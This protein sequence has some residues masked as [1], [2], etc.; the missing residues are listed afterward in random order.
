MELWEARQRAS[1]LIQKTN[2]D[3]D[4]V[5]AEMDAEQQV[6]AEILS[7]FTADRDKTLARVNAA[8]FISNGVLWAVAEA[9]DIPTYRAP[10]LAIPSGTVGIIAGVVPSIASMYTLKAINGKKKDSEAEPNM[11]AK[12]F[13]YP[14][15]A[16]I[17]Y[18]SSVWNYLHESPASEPGAKKRVDQ[19]IDRWIGDANIP[20]FNDR[21]S[22]KQLDVI[23]ASISQKKRPEYRHAH[24][25]HRDAATA[26]L[27]SLQ[28]EAA[29]ARTRHG[30]AWREA[31]LN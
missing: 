26:A 7:S 29:L 12:L 3:I 5:I 9:I 16:D 31:V 6:Y 27:R 22:K 8:S 4:F 17:D 30:Y 20:S 21:A 25:T 28:D 2:L 11:L 18:P 23:T 1:L 14:T 13:G 19:L 15:N 24:R 10:R